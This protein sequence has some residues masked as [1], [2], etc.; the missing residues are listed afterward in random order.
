MK[1]YTEEDISQLIQCKKL[2]TD[3][4]KAALKSSQNIRQN[5]LKLK[6]E[7]ESIFFE[8]IL[9]QNIELTDRFTVGLKHLQSPEDSRIFLIL[10]YN[11]R[12]AVPK[13]PKE[14]ENLHYQFHSHYIVADDLNKDITEPR[15]KKLEN[16][17]FFEE[18]VINFLHHINVENWTN[19]TYF[20][21]ISSNLL[22][23]DLFDDSQNY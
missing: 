7:T 15:E 22:N 14:H 2:I 23:Q 9:R 21:N 12:H 19:E 6:D 13:T 17:T 5:S 10:R 20:S 3:K 11:G 18:A 16:Y 4:P 1:D 8:V